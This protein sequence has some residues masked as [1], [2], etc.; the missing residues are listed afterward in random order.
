MINLICS[1]TH[2]WCEDGVQC[3]VLGSCHYA[4]V[5]AI[6]SIFFLFVLILYLISFIFEEILKWIEYPLTEEELD[7]YLDDR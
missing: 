6:V 1:I 3:K 2:Y 7:A 4:V 5:S